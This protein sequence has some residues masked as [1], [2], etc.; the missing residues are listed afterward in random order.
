MGVISEGASHGWGSAE[1][2]SALRNLVKAWTG[3]QKEQGARSPEP[4]P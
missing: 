3:C 2:G 1:D 4:R